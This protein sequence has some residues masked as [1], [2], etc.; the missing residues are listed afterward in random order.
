MKISRPFRAIARPRPALAASLAMLAAALLLAGSAQRMAGLAE[1]AHTAARETRDRLAAERK[2]TM[3]EA[4]AGLAAARQ[5]A[6]LADAGAF[7]DS[8]E[9]R[10][11]LLRAAQYALRLPGLRYTFGNSLPWPASQGGGNPAWIATPLQLELSLLHEGDLLALLEHLS[12]EQ[13]LLVSE[14]RVHRGQTA[15]L[16]ISPL[17]AE[18]ALYWLS[19]RGADG[20]A[21]PKRRPA[22]SMTPRPGAQDS[23]GRLLLSPAERRLLDRQRWTNPA[24]R[25]AEEGGDQALRLLGELRSGSGRR[26]RWL[27]GE[28]GAPAADE[29]L[30]LPVGD[31][32]LPATGKREPLLGESRLVIRRTGED[33]APR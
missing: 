10:R 14:C 28:D 15:P 27:D 24:Y 20:V 31:A 26:L 19:V 17:R 25:P 16:P 3:A 11:N 1:T 33:D 6:A 5:F 2:R 23:L 12:V 22:P 9:R 13:A 29:R 7:S 4:D 21:P 30:A 32:L 18:C 8:P